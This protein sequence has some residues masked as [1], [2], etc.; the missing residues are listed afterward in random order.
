VRCGAFVSVSTDDLMAM[1]VVPPGESGATTLSEFTA[2]T[3]GLS[4]SFGPNIDK[5][6]PLYA[7]WTY[8]PMQFQGEGMGTAP[9]GDPNVLIWRDFDVGRADDHRQDG[10]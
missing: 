2:K 10:R 3:A 5:Q 8:K 1:N 9:P 6:E 7:N 4:S